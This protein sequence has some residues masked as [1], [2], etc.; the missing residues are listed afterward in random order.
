MYRHST[1]SIVLLVSVS[2]VRC[3]QAPPAQYSSCSTE[4]IDHLY[5]ALEDR[6]HDAAA[7]LFCVPPEYSAVQDSEDR[8]MITAFFDLLH[9]RVGTPVD[10]SPSVGPRI[11]R[12]I[13]IGGGSGAYWSRQPHAGRD[14]TLS[15]DVR[16]SSGLTIQGRV[17]IFQPESV[18][19]IQSVHFGFP[20]N[21]AIF[22]ELQKELAR[23]R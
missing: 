23:L 10:R 16:F 2:L 20:P 18:C 1:C 7:E 19:C 21:S 4:L 17:F 9:E 13:G 6:S 3:T 11:G 14:L 8:E 12:T 5:K 15:H 22:A